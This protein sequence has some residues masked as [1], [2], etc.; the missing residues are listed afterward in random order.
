MLEIRDGVPAKPGN[1]RGR[2]AGVPA[3]GK[4]PGARTLTTAESESYMYETFPTSRTP[5]LLVLP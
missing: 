4:G 5:K 2:R 1:R 3:T